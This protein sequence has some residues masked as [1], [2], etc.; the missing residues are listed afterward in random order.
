MDKKPGSITLRNSQAV[1]VPA[2][3]WV[4]C[5]FVLADAIVEGTAGYAIRVGLLMAA[6]AYIVFVTLAKP[7]LKLDAEGLTV[8]NVAR[9]HRIPFG[10]LIDIRVGG[11]TSVV[12]S[13]PDG[14][15]KITSWNAP[16]VT[17]RRPRRETFGNRTQLQMLRRGEPASGESEVERL[18]RNRWE[19]WRQSPHD[20]RGSETVTSSWNKR[21]AIAVIAVVGINIAIRLR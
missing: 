7:A 18:I 21:E 10:A 12:A 3:I 15:R 16:G 6:V 19:A 11:L 13:T 2:V 4:F 5:A 20:D 8:A 17:R 14:E 9:T 1:W